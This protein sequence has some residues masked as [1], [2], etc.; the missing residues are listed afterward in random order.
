MNGTPT[1][2]YSPFKPTQ[3]FVYIYLAPFFS[4]FSYYLKP[5][6]YNL[7]DSAHLLFFYIML[8]VNSL[9]VSQG[10]PFS[11]LFILTTTALILS[12]CVL[13]LSYNPPSII[14]LECSF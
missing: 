7:L 14:L 3:S 12:L 10:C 6:A 13:C 8:S 11:F 4:F 5:R 2:K 9:N 1:V